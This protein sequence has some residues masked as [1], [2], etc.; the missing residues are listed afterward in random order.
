MKYN[1]INIISV[2]IEN[3][4]NKCLVLYVMNLVNGKILH[5]Q[6]ISDS[7]SPVGLNIIENW[8][9]LSYWNIADIRSDILSISIT[10]DRINKNEINL[11]SLNKY[12]KSESLKEIDNFRNV[13]ISVEYKLFSFPMGIKD[14]YNC[15]T[16]EGISSKYL[17]FILENNDI[18]EVES[19][20]LDGLSK[21]RK[22]SSKEEE[23]G[24]MNYNPMLRYNPLNILNE[25]VSVIGI[26]GVKS[27]HAKIESTSIIVCYGED[28]FFSHVK[29]IK[30][31]DM[32]P[33]DFNF[34]ILILVT[35]ILTGLTYV[36][37][38]KVMEKRLNSEWY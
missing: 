5:S 21:E 1:N 7:S 10:K 17:I 20:Y 25:N 27:T 13:N 18:I 2:V 15:V 29:P 26:K 32:L 11:S 6:I 35:L 16:L 23:N 24:I 8:V 14:I 33:S 12:M 9:I 30:P 36:L 22:L 3:K 4:K 37:K 38:M 31:F 19:K 34:K 28:L